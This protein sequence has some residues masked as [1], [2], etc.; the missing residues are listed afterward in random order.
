VSTLVIQHPVA[1]FQDWKKAF[2]SD[3]VGRVKNGVIGHVIYRSSDDP[4][5]V[6]VN[7]EFSSR[8]QAQ[9]FLQAL[10]ELWRRVGDEIGFGSP[11]AV[12]T[13]I[14]DEVERVDY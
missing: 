10:R 11:E 6:V 14:L 2:D 9:Q 8:D 3:P 5:Y 1:D 4:D 12:Q 7:L 13:R